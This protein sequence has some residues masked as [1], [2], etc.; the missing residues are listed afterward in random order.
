MARAQRLINILYQNSTGK[1]MKS[2][3]ITLLDYSGKEIEELIEKAI[4]VKSNISKYGKELEGKTLGMLFQK[5]STRTRA[6]F[7]AG[8]TQLG[9]HA[10]FLD[11]RTTNFTLGSLEDEFKSLSRYCDALMF[12]AY[13]NSDIVAAAQASSVPLINGLDELFHPCQGLADLM[14][15]KEKLGKLKGAKIAYI[16]DGNN[17]CNSLIIGCAKVGAQISVATPKGFE[18]YKKAIELGEKEGLL[19]LSNDPIEAVKEAEVVYTDTW[20]SMGEE[21]QKKEKM[22]KFVGYTVDKKLLGNAFFMHCLPAHRGYEVADEVID[23]DKSIVFDQAENRMHS[24]KALL[25]KLMKE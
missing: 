16:G 10:I 19:K 5:T 9:G 6:S 20:I 4:E 13:K 1:N 21:D 23:S 22:K 7:E 25:L 12:R 3:F 24:Q 15:I 14:T 11:W 17:V 2:D 8:M 18:P